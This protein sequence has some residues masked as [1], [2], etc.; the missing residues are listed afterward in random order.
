MKLRR[1]SM[2]GGTSLQASASRGC[3]AHRPRRPPRAFS[4][5][6]S[7][8]FYDR[9]ALGNVLTAARVNVI[10]QQQF[11]IANPDFFGMLPAVSTLPGPVPPSTIEQI[12]STMSSYLMQTVAGWERQTAARCNRRGELMRI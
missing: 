12:S 1:T 11:V 9:F 10:V 8:I 5:P 3:L 2:N 7:G 6:V 4:G